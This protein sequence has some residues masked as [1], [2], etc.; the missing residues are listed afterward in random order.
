MP[1]LISSRRDFMKRAGGFLGS[2]LSAP[3]SLATQPKQNSW[4]DLFCILAERSSDF[5][6]SVKSAALIGKVPF[7]LDDFRYSLHI[8]RYIRDGLKHSASFKFPNVSYAAELL[9]QFETGPR[10][11]LVMDP[12]KGPGLAMLRASPKFQSILTSILSAKGFSSDFKLDPENPDFNFIESQTIN[13]LLWSLK[14]TEGLQL[15]YG[16]KLIDAAKRK[17]CL[18]AEVIKIFENPDIATSLS[19]NP[20]FKAFADLGDGLSTLYGEGEYHFHF[21]YFGSCY[22]TLNA[23]EHSELIYQSTRILEENGIAIP[24]DIKRIIIRTEFECS[25]DDSLR[26]SKKSQAPQMPKCLSERINSLFPS[27]WSSHQAGTQWQAY[28]PDSNSI[29]NIQ[30][31]DGNMNRR[32]GWIFRL[33]PQVGQ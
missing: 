14:Q 29:L 20:I 31:F 8:C 25:W 5:F 16:K 3:T 18:G 33:A 21:D 1:E 32:E 17:D 26:D 6:Q 4:V 28:C 30:F 15:L 7:D 9:A 11:S 13:H 19:N 27:K 10:H 2:L 22:E 12:A 24:E 23:S